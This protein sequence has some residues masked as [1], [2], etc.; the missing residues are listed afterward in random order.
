MEWWYVF[1]VEGSNGVDRFVNI[2]IM[3]FFSLQLLIFSR[4]IFLVKTLTRP[5]GL[6]LDPAA[7]F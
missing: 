5:V 6:K 4:E 1:Y 2:I 7:V 3:S